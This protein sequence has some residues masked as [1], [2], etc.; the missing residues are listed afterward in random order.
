M[1]RALGFGDDVDHLI[2]GLLE[3]Y[4]KVGQ[5]IKVSELGGIKRDDYYSRLDEMVRKAMEDSELSFN[6]VIPG[7]DDL[8]SIFE[9]AY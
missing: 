4:R 8:S 9:G 5:P 7:E 2:K 1:S 6:P 3:F